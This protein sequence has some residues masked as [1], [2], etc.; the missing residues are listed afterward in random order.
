[1][2][3]EKK[4]GLWAKIGAFGLKNPIASLFALVIAYYAAKIYIFGGDTFTNKAILYALFVAWGVYFVVRH[5]FKVLLAL[6]ILGGIGYG[7]YAYS[8]KEIKKCEDSG[9]KWNEE[10]QTCEFE[11][12][13]LDKLKNAWQILSIKIKDLSEADKS[14]ENDTAPE[15]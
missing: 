5:L 13:F 7:I 6:I 8:Q 12:T 3:E 11:E 14:Q 4:V 9:G 2:Q 1:M 10:T 15:K